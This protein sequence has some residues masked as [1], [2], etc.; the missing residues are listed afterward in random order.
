MKHQREAWSR[1]TLVTPVVAVAAVLLVPIVV[2]ALGLSTFDGEHGPSDDIGG[3]LARRS[4]HQSRH[5]VR[6][7]PVTDVERSDLP[8]GLRSV[9]FGV[10]VEAGDPQLVAEV[11]AAAGGAEVGIVRVFARWDTEFPS[12]RHRA[13]LD[14]GRTIHLS[15]RPRTESG[16]IIPWAEVATAAPGSAVHDTLLRWVRAVAPNGDQIYF[17]FNH[18]PETAQSDGGG[19]PE[20]FVAAWRRTVELLRSVG[21]DEVPTVLVLGHGPYRTGEVWRWYPGDDVVD[22]VGVDPYN[23]YRCQGTNRPWT[24]PQDLIAA[25][26]EFADERGKPLAIP[27]I[28]STE[29]P[30]DPTR[31]AEWILDLA[32]TLGSPEV[33][34]RIAFAAWFDA[35]DPTWPS[36]RWGIDSSPA[37][38]DAFATLLTALSPP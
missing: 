14:A 35:H 23:W 6:S 12:S 22:V 29:D 30:D 4:D 20:E 11:E 36:C 17:T 27:E 1:P 26:L 37:S 13:L 31:K 5:D 7:R 33:A 16:R 32:A 10:S 15:V 3:G 2:A 25:P 21:G 19:T 8:D 34:D 18:E 38:A 28:A 9:R 24:S